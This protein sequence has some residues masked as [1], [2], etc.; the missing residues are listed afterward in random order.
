MNDYFSLSKVFREW[1]LWFLATGG[2]GHRSDCPLFGFTA[3][4]RSVKFRFPKAAGRHWVQGAQ[5]GPSI[6]QNSNGRF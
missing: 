2:S 5:S 1:Q 4:K 6:L 3:G